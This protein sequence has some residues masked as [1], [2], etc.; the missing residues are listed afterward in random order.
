MKTKLTKKQWMKMGKT[1]HSIA[2]ELKMQVPL[3]QGEEQMAMVRVRDHI[4]MAAYS[5]SLEA[6]RRT[7]R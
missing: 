3:A 1:L 7:K 5:A 2:D 6:H 4:R